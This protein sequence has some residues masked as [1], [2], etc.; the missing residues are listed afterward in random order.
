MVKKNLFI[1]I[2]WI[3]DRLS[4]GGRFSIENILRSIIIN[5]KFDKFNIIFVLNKNILKKFKF[6]NKYKK[7]ILT[8]QKYLN[9][10]IRWFI[11]FFLYKKEKSQIYFCPNI[12]S[13][14]FKL[15][16]KI[17]NLF[18]DAQWIKFPNNFSLL[19]KL[20]IKFNILVCKI[21]SDKII[22]TSQSLR[23]DLEKKI[24]FKN[25]V[26]IIYLPFFKQKINLNKKYNFKKNSFILCISSRLPHKN[27]ETIEKLFL[28]YKNKIKEKLIIAGLGE[29]RIKKNYHN[30]KYMQ[31]IDEKKKIWLIKNS[32]CVLLPSKYEGFGMVAIETIING[33]RILASE[34]T[35]Y[36][37]LIGNN[38]IY[39]STPEK[40]ENWLEKILSLNKNKNKNKNKKKFL[41][42]F[43]HKIISNKYFTCLAN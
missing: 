16:F 37:E 20:W 9:F 6:L 22:F 8:D 43:N 2:S 15:N 35:I 13:P 11:L 17:V 36:K 29:D 1:D 40:I 33:G 21:K 30:I 3:D 25:K 41:N 5:K 14:I 18:H 19:R 4:G 31:F 32:K 10:I 26:Y 23:R 24:N 27:L 34:L 38:A 12:Y 7:I 28:K 42:K 39:I